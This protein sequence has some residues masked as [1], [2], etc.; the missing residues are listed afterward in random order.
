MKIGDPILRRVTE[1]VH[2]IEKQ[3]NALEEIDNFDFKKKDQF[4]LLISVSKILRSISDCD[5]SQIYM[6]TNSNYELCF[7][8]P[9]NEHPVSLEV[10]ENIEPK[11]IL[12]IINQKKEQR[13]LL[14]LRIGARFIPECLLI[15]KE[16]YFGRPNSKIHDKEFQTYLVYIAKKL[17]EKIDGYTNF[18]MLENHR[19]LSM[20]FL[21]IYQKRSTESNI[22]ETQKDENFWTIILGSTFDYLP[23]WGPLIINEVKPR[24]QILK[25]QKGRQFLVLLAE[26]EIK[27]DEWKIGIRNLNLERVHTLCGLLLD[28][29][30]MGAKDT[31]LMVNPK[32]HPE[33]YASILFAEGNIPE[34]ELIIPV[35]DSNGKTIVLFNFEHN[36]K[37]AFSEFHIKMLLKM[38]N[39]VEV[40]INYAIYKF[41]QQID[42]EKKLRYLMLRI[43]NKLFDTQQHKLKNDLGELYSALWEVDS[44]IR[45]NHNDLALKA[46]ENAKSNYK[47]IKEISLNF[48]ISIG[49]YLQYGKKKI[50]DIV[51]NYLPDFK[52][53]ISLLGDNIIINSQDIPK[54]KFVFC[55]GMVQ[56]HFH[57]ILQNSIDQ[58]V[59]IRKKSDKNFVG[60]IKINYRVIP[61]NDKKANIHTYDLIEIT[62]SDNGGGVPRG[63]EEWIFGP[64]NTLK[65][66]EGGQGFGLY[67][68]REYMKEI[69]GDLVLAN[70]HPNGVT[71]KIQ[72][73][74][75]IEG[76]HEGMAEQL[77]IKEGE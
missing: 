38:V 16:T 77:N 40:F 42:I 13:S 57:N 29:E 44:E 2:S 64:K 56:E 24:V 6:K 36:Q 12:K 53:R 35:K 39:D 48:N 50:Y 67:A 59:S 45:A 72:F 41:E 71:F 32:E 8:Y 58:F 69:G 18:R 14:V 19:K 54:D 4:E 3:F 75:Y 15:L 9:Q 73:P 30:D 62:I 31:Y 17:S 52:K 74:E 47:T 76:L 27:N 22:E 23:L 70:D 43:A 10:D 46:V 1:T 26:S 37:N 21:N 51:N 33:R 61:K 55:S 65:A 66:E 11:N 28:N 7:N 25:V 60:E 49:D 5:T 20:R 68:A 63:K 34:S